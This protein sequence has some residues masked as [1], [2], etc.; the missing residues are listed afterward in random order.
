ML[1]YAEWHFSVKPSVHDAR[2]GHIVP[3]PMESIGRCSFLCPVAAL[4]IG[5]LSRQR[6]RED[7]AIGVVLRA[8]SLLGVVMISRTKSY[9]DFP[10]CCLEMSWE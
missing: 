5:W 8:C 10:T 1:S 6:L 3:Q 4:G 9:R 2:L 7:T